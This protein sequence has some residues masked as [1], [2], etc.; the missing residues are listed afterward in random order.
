[1]SRTLSPN[2]TLLNNANANATTILTRSMKTLL[3]SDSGNFIIDVSAQQDRTK[4]A[5]LDS[6]HFTSTEKE[7][8]NITHHNTSTIHFP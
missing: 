3:G 6:T 4:Q 5:K 1:M 7:N 8:A 2:E